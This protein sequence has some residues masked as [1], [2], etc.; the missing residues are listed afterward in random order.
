MGCCNMKYD[1]RYEIENS[2]EDSFQWPEVMTPADVQN[3]LGIGSSTFY[4]LVK[5]G[6]LPAFKIG[7][8]WRVNHSDLKHFCANN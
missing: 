3:Y 4:Q 5:S 1:Y 2:D 7:K 6:K 8:L